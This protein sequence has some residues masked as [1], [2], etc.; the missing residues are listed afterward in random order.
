MA[1][2]WVTLTER[3]EWPANGARNIRRTWPQKTSW[4]PPLAR[5]FAHHR[6]RGSNRRLNLTPATHDK[7]RE[8]HPPY[9]GSR[10]T[11]TTFPRFSVFVFCFLFLFYLYGY[12]CNFLPKCRNPRMKSHAAKIYLPSIQCMARKDVRI[13]ANGGEP[14]EDSGEVRVADGSKSRVP[15]RKACT[16]PSIR[17][18]FLCSSPPFFHYQG[19]YLIKH[20]VLCILTPCKLHFPAFE[21]HNHRLQTGF[22]SSPP[23]R[24]ERV[25]TTFPRHPSPL[26]LL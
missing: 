21:V 18:A 11:A 1:A 20:L 3:H 15:V 10:S 9:W 12:H 2:K 17:S 4:Q 24:P 7:L 8:F 22:T 25:I 19:W 5:C 23:R 16:L 13:P 6:S 26:P 14:W